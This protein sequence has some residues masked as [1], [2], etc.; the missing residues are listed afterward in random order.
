MQF[1]CWWFGVVL[2]QVIPSEVQD[3]TGD[4]IEK[5]GKILNQATCHSIF[6]SISACLIF[7]FLCGW[8]VSIYSV[9][10]GS[11]AISDFS[12]IHTCLLF[13]LVSEFLWH[14]Y[15]QYVAVVSPFQTQ[16]LDGESLFM[17]DSTA[18]KWI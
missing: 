1:T 9:I 2:S 15:V 6:L 13:F 16:S 10:F 12:L 18:N 11:V 3:N 7:F 14:F 4:N 5:P 17:L 8:R